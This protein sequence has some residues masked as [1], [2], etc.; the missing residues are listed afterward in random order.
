MR[1]HSQIARFAILPC[2]SAGLAL[3]R[4][5]WQDTGNVWSKLDLKVYL[6]DPDLGWRRTEMGYTWIGLDSIAVLLCLAVGV[7]IVARVLQGRRGRGVLWGQRAAQCVAAASL[8]LPAYA[9]WGGLPESGA[10]ETRP[11]AVIE[12]PTG[13][14]NASLVGAPSGRYVVVSHPEPARSAPRRVLHLHIPNTASSGRP[15]NNTIN[16]G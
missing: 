11:T 5:L 1:T 10:K 2:V 3:I 7:Y 8:L 14:V 15:R 12:A 13:G 6:P 16:L 4:W 9:F